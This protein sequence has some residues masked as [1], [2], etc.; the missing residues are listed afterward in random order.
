MLKQWW[1]QILRSC[2]SLG[3]RPYISSNNRLHTSHIILQTSYFRRHISDVILRQMSY[4]RRHISDVILQCHIMSD[5]I[6][7]TSYF[8]R[9]TSDVILRQTSYFRRHISDVRIQTSYFRRHTS[10][11]LIQIY[12]QSGYLHAENQR[13]PASLHVS[14]CSTNELESGGKD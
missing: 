8:R 10:D 2:T 4:F 5:V 9:H 1:S 3:V 14:L 11:I 12:G 6:L 13:L 7:R